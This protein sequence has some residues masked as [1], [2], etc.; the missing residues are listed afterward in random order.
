MATNN[1]ASSSLR[2]MH[3]DFEAF[4]VVGMSLKS[5]LDSDFA[6][7]IGGSAVFNDGAQLLALE[8]IS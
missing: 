2:V 4:D 7:G 1:G 8:A 5:L 3:A 6:E